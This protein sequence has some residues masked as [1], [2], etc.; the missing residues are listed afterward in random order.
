MQEDRIMGL[1]NWVRGALTNEKHVDVPADN[2]AMAVLYEILYI[3]SHPCKCGGDWA[4]VDSGISFPTAYKSCRCCSCLK[5][6]KFVFQ[7]PPT[8]V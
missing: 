3:K 2:I 4:I 8:A 7:L 6:I 1:L 5:E